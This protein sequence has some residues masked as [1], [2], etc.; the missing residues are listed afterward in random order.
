MNK[1]VKRLFSYRNHLESVKSGVIGYNID[2]VT[3]EWIDRDINVNAHIYNPF[4]EVIVRGVRNEIFNVSGK[5]FLD[6]VG[7]FATLNFGHCHPKIA[8]AMKNQ[9]DVL[10]HTG[11]YLLNDKM[12]PCQELISETFGYEK[13]IMMN[14]GAE[15]CE[16]AV[17]MAKRWGCIVKGIPMNEARVV[18]PT[19]NFWGKTIAAA[20]I[21][22]DPLRSEGFGPYGLGLDLVDY[23]DLEALETYFKENPNCS[24]YLFEPIQGRA[25][26]IIPDDGYLKGVRH[27]CTKYNVLMMADEVQC[28]LGR[29][30]YLKAVD[31]ESVRP[32]V[33]VMAKAISGGYYPVSIVL[34]DDHIMKVW[35]AGMHGST[36]SSTP[37]GCTVVMASLQVLREEN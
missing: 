34:A 11:R 26:I 7:G 21:T 17:K 30:G 18:F 35:G 22:D 10:T 31:Y 27:L 24:G 12:V 20:A 19:K 28:G 4:P 1:L 6:C 9:L 13:S 14:S 2:S 15:A 36:F 37:L 33:L 25:G 29:T 8:D 3:Q 23:N 5:R 16:T 32:D